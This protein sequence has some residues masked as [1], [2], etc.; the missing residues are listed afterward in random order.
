[1]Y[2][3]GDE[4]MEMD[5]SAICNYLESGWYT[6][7]VRLG[8]P[9]WSEPYYDETGAGA[10][11]LM[12]TYSVPIYTRDDEHRLIGIVTGNLLIEKGS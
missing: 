9:M 1:V 4:I 8:Q 11:V 5:P 10:N 6:E 7:P 2:R 3:E 12:I